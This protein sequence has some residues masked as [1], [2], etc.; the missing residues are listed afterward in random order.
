M[1]AARAASYERLSNWLVTIRSPSVSRTLLNQNAIDL[2]A[3]EFAVYSADSV[4]LL[5]DKF[6]IRNA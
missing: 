5:A 2:A 1:L 4:L 6:P 3:N